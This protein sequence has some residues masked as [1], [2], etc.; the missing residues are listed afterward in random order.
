MS[1]KAILRIDNAQKYYNRGRENEIHVMNGISLSLP[2]SGMIAIFGKSGCGK[3]TLLNT[4]G[5]L[6]SLA[7][8]S[9]EIFGENL[10]NDPD[11]IRNRYTGYI[12]QNY[13]LN[14][15]ETVFENVADALR[16]CGVEDEQ[17]IRTRV[18]AALADVD[19]DKF[20]ERTPDTLSGGQQQRVAIARAIVKSPAI[21]LADEPTGNLDENNTVL[22]MDIL[23]EISRTRLV[24]L[25]THEANLVDYYCDRVIEMAD[26]RIVGDRANTGATGYVQRN[27]NDIFLGDLATRTDNLPGVSLTTYGDLPADRPV[28]IRLSARGGG[29]SLPAIPPVSVS[30]MRLPRSICGRAASRL[31]RTRRTPT[32]AESRWICRHWDRLRAG[33]SGGCTI[34]AT[35]FPWRGGRTTRNAARGASGSSACV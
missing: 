25:V 24:L 2:E 3:T 17:V 15:G 13:N 4:I 35:R 7:S 1:E 31:R 21:I 28:H 26:G 12:F 20:R 34:S 30:W 11:I 22:V 18:L 8:G 19:M 27:K 9:I 16:L 23:K 5:G 33:T 14:V 6:D 10:A 29:C 32:G